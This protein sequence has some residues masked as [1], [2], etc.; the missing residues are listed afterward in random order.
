MYRCSVRPDGY[1]PALHIYHIAARRRTT[2]N[3]FYGRP[4]GSFPTLSKC[5]DT[6]SHR[7]G[8]GLAIDRRLAVSR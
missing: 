5:L 4:G 7:Y 6:V 1:R 2:G 8:N 3:R